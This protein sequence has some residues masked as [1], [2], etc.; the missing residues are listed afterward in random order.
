MFNDFSSNVS[1]TRK[2][3]IFNLRF[4][5]FQ[6]SFA[7][8]LYLIKNWGDSDYLQNIAY[9]D[10]SLRFTNN[11]LVIEED[12]PEGCYLKLSREDFIKFINY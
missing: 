9:G 10:F 7:N 1:K 2:G 6:F 3:I 4:C 11:F 12:D 8:L 5:S